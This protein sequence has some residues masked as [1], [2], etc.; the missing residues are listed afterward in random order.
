MINELVSCIIHGIIT[1]AVWELIRPFI[2]RPVRQP[3][4]ERRKW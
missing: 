1:I 2:N 3:V 4:R